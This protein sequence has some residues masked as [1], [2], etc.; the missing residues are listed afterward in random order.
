MVGLAKKLIT[1]TKENFLTKKFS[2]LHHKNK[3][4]QQRS[5]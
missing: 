2:K 4:N 5:P 1:K 3:S